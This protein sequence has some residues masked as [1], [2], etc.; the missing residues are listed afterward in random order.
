[1]P[2]H[3]RASLREHAARS[4]P[5][6]RSRK[7]RTVTATQQQQAAETATAELRESL[8]QEQKKTAALTQEVGAAAPGDD[9][10]RRASNAARSTEAQARASGTRERACCGTRR[11]IETQA[12]QLQKVDRC[13]HAAEDRRRSAP[14]RNCGNR[15][16]RSA[17]RSEQ[18]H[19]ISHPHGAPWTSARPSGARRTVDQSDRPGD[20]RPRARQ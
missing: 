1:M 20:A 14:S 6:P 2:R 19:A 17:T 3:S 12:A 4:R 10:E 7:R 16:S 15:C 18:W 8:Q 5:R 13:G 11:E 9:G